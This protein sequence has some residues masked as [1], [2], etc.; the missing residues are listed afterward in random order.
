M[1]ISN[2]K[3]LFNNIQAFIVCIFL[4]LAIFEFFVFSNLSCFGM[5]LFNSLVQNLKFEPNCFT[6]MLILYSIKICIYIMRVHTF[7][8]SNIVILLFCL[9]NIKYFK[10]CSCNFI[11]HKKCVSQNNRIFRQMQYFEWV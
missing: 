10:L 4:I 5:L 3:W 6:K 1:I 9:P 11:Y 2:K 8:I 7:T